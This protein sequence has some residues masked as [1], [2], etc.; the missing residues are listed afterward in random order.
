MAVFLKS[1][2]SLARYAHDHFVLFLFRIFA[3]ILT[4]FSSTTV[5]NRRVSLP[6]VDFF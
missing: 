4:S 1:R 6:S 2:T 3:G 5:F